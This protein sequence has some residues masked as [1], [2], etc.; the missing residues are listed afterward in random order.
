MRETHI[1]G[2]AYGNNDIA[3]NPPNIPYLQGDAINIM[4]N[5]AARVVRTPMLV[6]AGITN[7]GV[8]SKE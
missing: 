3:K 6:Y 8:L 5:E 7:P 4:E 2:H 1:I